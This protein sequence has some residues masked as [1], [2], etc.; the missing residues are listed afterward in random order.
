MVSR[1]DFAQWDNLARGATQARAANGGATLSAE[2]NPVSLP[3]RARAGEHEAGEVIADRYR[4][5]RPIGRGGSGMVFLAEHIVLDKRMAL[6]ILSRSL[7][8]NPDQMQRFIREARAASRIGH[9][10]II[11]VTDFGATSSGSAF[12]AMEFVPGRDLSLRLQAE[13]PLPSWLACRIAVDACSA[14]AAAHGHGI[15]H[16]DLK[17]ENMMLAEHA[18]RPDQIKILDFGIARMNGDA[19]ARPAHAGAVLGTP[20]FMAPEQSGDGPQDHRVDIYALGCVMYELLT[21]SP[22]FDGGSVL[23]LLA[24]HRST[25]PQPLRERAPQR[26]IPAAVEGAVL[27]ALEKEP[28]RRFQSMAD[29]G[30]AFAAAGDGPA[31]LRGPAHHLASRSVLGALLH[32]A[33]RA[34]QNGELELAL[35]LVAR[36]VSSLGETGDGARPAIAPPPTGIR[37]LI[38]AAAARLALAR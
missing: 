21:G 1:D 8:R 3:P 27:R 24:R 22:P 5:V 16:R 17:P 36:V 2:R 4:L 34:A 19:G 31:V 9:P 10:G 32:D 28:E 7:A 14:L 23:E 38:D 11:N 25:R 20:A 18:G 29:M 12:F 35:D 30:A 15:V 6:K 33:R 37:H 26:E 13:G